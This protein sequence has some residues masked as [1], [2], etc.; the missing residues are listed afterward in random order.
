MVHIDN[1]EHVWHNGITK[2]SSPNA[3]VNYKSIG[4]AS[5]ISNRTFH[6]LP[7]GNSLGDYIPFYFWYKM[8]MLFVIQRGFNGVNITQPN[9]IVYCVTT[10]AEIIQSEVD[11][12]F[13]DGH[14]VDGFTTVYEP[15]DISKIDTLLDFVAIR[16][17]YWK[18]EKDLDKKRRKEAEFLVSDDIPKEAIQVFGVYNAAAKNKLL[19][20]GIPENKIIIR[21]DIYFQ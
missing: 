13:T 15:K 8:P 17:S 12:V 5:L 18:D 10:V 21:P 1:V 7:N 2:I 11:Y 6:F 20:L 4:D 9:D 19:G 16:D 3:N 14:A